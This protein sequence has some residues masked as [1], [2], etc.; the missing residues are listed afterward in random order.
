MAREQFSLMPTEKNAAD[1][2]ELWVNGLIFGLI[3]NENGVYSFKDEENGDPLDDYWT[4]LAKDRAEAFDLLRRSRDKVQNSF[5]KYI[6]EIRTSRGVDE[7]NTII[8]DAKVNYLNKFSQN[9]ISTAD[10]KLRINKETADLLRNELRY[11][12]D[13]LGENV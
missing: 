12:K 10:L 2:T 8:S 5:E 11:V 3:K 1:M 13:K 7:F 4:P 9:D 6:S